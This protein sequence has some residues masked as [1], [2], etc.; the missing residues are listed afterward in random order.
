MKDHLGNT[1]VIFA[2]TNNDDIPEIIQEADYYPFG[3]RH[4]NTTATNHYLYNGKE[5]NT[6]LGLD[7]YDYG[8]RWLDVETGRWSSIDPM[9]ESYT[10]MSPYNYVANNPIANIDPDGRFI[11]A[12]RNKRQNEVLKKMVRIMREEAKTWTREE[13]ASVR[14]ITG[15]TKRGFMNLFIP[16]QGPVLRFA[17]T[18]GRDNILD[19]EKIDF[20][21]NKGDGTPLKDTY[22]VTSGGRLNDNP[23]IT[24]DKKIFWLVDNFMRM[25]ERGK[26]YGSFIPGGGLLRPKNYGAFMAAEERGFY[27]FITGVFGHELG[28]AGSR[29]GWQDDSAHGFGN[30][31]EKGFR[32]EEEV[33]GG[34]IGYRSPQAGFGVY[35]RY[36]HYQYRNGGYDEEREGKI[37]EL[38]KLR[39]PHLV[40][41]P[42]NP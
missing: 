33:L 16:G 27:R 25:K 22:A 17:F 24:F 38:F 21:T 14:D 15:L 30:P 35:A 10:P 37:Q 42:R 18:D 4:Q 29:I 39:Y 20:M 26:P 23:V 9:A 7:W 36:L 13:W 31:D 32:F 3:M 6:D 2:D 28:H 1:R 41:K 19:D 12:G 5:L 8:A 11:L 34:I 40:H